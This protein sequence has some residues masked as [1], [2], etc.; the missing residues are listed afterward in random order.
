VSAIDHIS[1]WV[2][3]HREIDRVESQIINEV[4][5][6]EV[7]GLSVSS[8]KGA[9]GNPLGAAGAIQAGCAALCVRD[10]FV[11][12]TVNWKYPDPHCALNL[13]AETRFSRLRNVLVNS[14][15]LSGTNSCL[16]LSEC[17]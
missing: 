2:P 4:F 9:I 6:A 14:H 5:G 11:P 8:I 7:E 3:G 1:A 13:S 10:S 15:G 12:P 16:V 17:A